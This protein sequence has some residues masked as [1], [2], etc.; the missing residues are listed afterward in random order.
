MA[1]LLIDQIRQA[2]TVETDLPMPEDP[3]AR[4]LARLCLDEPA[5]EI[6]VIVSRIPLSR[7]S[8]ERKFEHETGMSLGRWRTRARL[9]EAMRLLTNSATVS[10][11]SW[12]VGYQSPSAFIHAYREHFGVTPGKM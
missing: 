11:A 2:L 8:L 10:E 5:T 4:H 3:H 1:T 6:K 7:R 9:V 12:Q